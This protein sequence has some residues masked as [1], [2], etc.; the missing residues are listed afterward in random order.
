MR[1][2][3][4]IF[5][6]PAA[7]FVVV[8]IVY[9]ALTGFNEWVGL[10]CLI[11]SAGLSFMIGIYLRMLDRRHGTLPEDVPEAEIAEGAGEQGFF[12]PWSWWPLV[13][14]LAAA[15]GFTALAV[16]WWIMVPAGFLTVI[17]LVGWVFEFSR[18]RFAH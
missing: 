3:M 10:T 14:G 12:P 7:F 15:L 9:G 8:A 17:G 18:G 4:W 2:S 13:A 16:G 5:N 11:L 6:I 1:A